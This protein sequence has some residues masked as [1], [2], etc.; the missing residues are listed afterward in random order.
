MPLFNATNIFPCTL[1]STLAISPG[2]TCT[3]EC[4]GL[5][6]TSGKNQM[7]YFVTCQKGECAGDLMRLSD[8][9]CC[10]HLFPGLTES[11][12][13]AACS[14][15]GQRVLHLDRYVSTLILDTSV[16]GSKNQ[17]NCQGLCETESVDTS[18][19]GYLLTTKSFM[20]QYEINPVII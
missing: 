8:N 2:V 19:C 14:R 10:F 9:A 13:A 3:C 20:T 16:T 6:A 12:I 15:V 18:L 1:N 17:D 5:L 11:V 4:Y 7:K